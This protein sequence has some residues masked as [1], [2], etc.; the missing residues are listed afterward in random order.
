MRSV[1][2]ILSV[3]QSIGSKM[4]PPS[5]LLPSVCGWLKQAIRDQSSFPRG[6]QGAAGMRVNY[7]GPS[8]VGGASETVP[9]FDGLCLL[10]ASWG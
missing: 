3:S 7:F 10:R 2:Y 5:L 8:P 9:A 4:R 1:A 6:S